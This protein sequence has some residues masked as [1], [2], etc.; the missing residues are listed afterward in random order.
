MKK[1]TK[2]YIYYGLVWSL[3]PAFFFSFFGVEE[4]FSSA[5]EELVFRTAYLVTSIIVFVI[6]YGLFVLYYCL[7]V[8]TSGYA[9]LEHE[10]SCKRGILFKKRSIVEYQKMHAINKK[11][12]FIQQWFGIAIL[13][14][15]S[16]STNTASQAE[17]VIIETEQVI[18]QL[19]IILKEKQNG[20]ENVL[21][22]T[23]RTEAKQEN[24]YT[25]R[26]RF[27]I[28]YSVLNVLMSLVCLLCIGIITW[29]GLGIC[30]PFIDFTGEL[31]I[32]QF[33]I[34]A[35]FVTIVVI[36]FIG[37]I[38]FIGSILF[39]FIRYYQFRIFKIGNELQICY[40][41]FVKSD[42]RFLLSKIKAIKIHQNLIQRIFH[43]A[44]IYLEVVGYCES[45]NTNNQNV[46]QI[47]ILIPLCK[48]DCI[49]TL[50]Q[51]ILPDYV[52]L[53]KE[54]NAKSFASF[55]AWPILITTIS[56]LFPTLLIEIS[57]LIAEVSFDICLIVIASACIL[58]ILVDVYILVGALF[59]YHN[60]GIAING[61]K[62]TLYNGTIT[63]KTTVILRKNIIAIEDITTAKRKKKGIYSFRIH[64]FTNALTNVVTI[65]HIDER[66]R[67]QLLNSLVD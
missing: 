28:M 45:T 52:P 43:F 32:Q 62:F 51:N 18:D 42:N 44:T 25:F 29:I 15:D 24:L 46:E 19:L 65:K 11:Q 54:E 5:E 16:G 27:K 63:K 59:A 58:M 60:H 39:S 22:T 23:S 34:S 50:L 67:H 33:L 38:T 36:L 48:E 57:L 41:L 55:L 4:F 14:I 1:F 9:C 35:M 6:V 2:K 13:T 66:V 61:D 8:N 17:I 49:S 53:A 21:E 12:N 20:K 26:S 3:L 37:C 10:I 64:F 40:G 30:F 31:T 56:I 47:G 7:Y